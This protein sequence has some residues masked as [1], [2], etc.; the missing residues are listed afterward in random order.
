MLGIFHAVIMQNRLAA[1]MR[2][3][4]RPLG[5]LASCNFIMRK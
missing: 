3:K 2:Q 5:L 1:I 4:A